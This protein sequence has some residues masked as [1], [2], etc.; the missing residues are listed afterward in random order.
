MIDSQSEEIAGT[1]TLSGWALDPKAEHGPG[2]DAIHVWAYPLG[3]LPVFL[4]ATTLTENRPDA[5]AIHGSKT[6]RSGYALPIRSL[7][8]GTY[9]LA[10]FAWSAAERAVLPAK[11]VRITVR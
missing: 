5:A 10:V 2:I 8:P 4:G 3:G 11:T 6:L 9:D 7:S 1:F